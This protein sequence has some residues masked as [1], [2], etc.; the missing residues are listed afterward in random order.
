MTNE[1]KNIFIVALLFL[2][3]ILGAFLIFYLVENLQAAADL[4]ESMRLILEELRMVIEEAQEQLG[5]LDQGF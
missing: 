3:T 4:N 1:T 5:L 2:W